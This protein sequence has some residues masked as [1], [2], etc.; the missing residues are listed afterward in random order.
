MLRFFLLF[1][2]LIFMDLIYSLSLL[3]CAWPLM[4]LLGS[5]YFF[6]LTSWGLPPV[7]IPLWSANDLGRGCAQTTWASKVSTLYLWLSVGWNHIKV[8]PVLQSPHLY[9][10]PVLRSHLSIRAVSQKAVDVGRGFCRS[11]L[12]SIFP[13]NFWLVCLSSC[14]NHHCNQARRVVHFTCLFPTSLL[15][16]M[17]LHP[18]VSASNE[19][20]CILATKLKVF[21]ASPVLFKLLC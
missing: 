5:S 16:G 12:S 18:P 11:L 8:Q 7:C 4:S 15:M 17:S 2:F 20:L 21:M 19:G 14:P 13:W 1:C 10:P 6:S 9:F 3:G